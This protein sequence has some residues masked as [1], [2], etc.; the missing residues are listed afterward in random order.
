MLSFLAMQLIPGDP[1]DVMLGPMSTVSDDARALL[2]EE[3][4]LTLPVWQQFLNHIGNVV[5]LNF[6]TSFHTGKSVLL[7]LGEQAMPTL[8][9]ATVTLVFSFLVAVLMAFITRKGF[10]RSIAHLGELF[11]ISAPNFWI[12][13]ILLFIFNHQL[14]LIPVLSGNEAAKL[15]L[16]VLA[17]ALSISAT[18][19]QLLRSGLDA[20]E[21]EPW[22][23]T[24]KSRGNSDMRMVHRHGLRHALASTTTL[25]GYIFGALLGGT[26]LIE[27]VFSRPGLGRVAL[28]AIDSRDMPIVMAII[29]FSALIFI[30]MNWLIDIASALLDPRVR[31]A[32]N[33]EVAAN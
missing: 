4:G 22:F 21:S 19:G 1:V 18:L 8:T 9:L 17:L 11:A 3:L 28:D 20:T 24:A 29:V 2:R 5:T 13:L 15:I 12:A 33:L 27:T 30:M 23:F 25:T 7:I 31:Q 26:V 16:P 10:F 14:N 32:Q 6:G